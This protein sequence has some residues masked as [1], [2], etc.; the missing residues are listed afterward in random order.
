LIEA[1][2]QPLVARCAAVAVRADVKFCIDTSGA[3]E[4]DEDIMAST[5]ACSQS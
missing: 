4:S 5:A 2:D 1:V 3:A